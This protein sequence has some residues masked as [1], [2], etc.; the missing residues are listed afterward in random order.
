MKE[1]QSKTFNLKALDVDNKTKS[2][3]VAIAEL[4]TIDRDNDVFD[5]S[6]FDVTIKQRGPNGT[7]EIWH[8]SDHT[9]KSLSALSKFSELGRD[10]K[11]EI[12]RKYLL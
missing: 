6:A 1:Y 7:N 11:N 2:V 3:K 9:S 10:G 8:L 5:P 4:E 12:L